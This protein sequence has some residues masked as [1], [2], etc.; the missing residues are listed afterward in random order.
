[1]SIFTFIRIVLNITHRN[2]ISF[3]TKDQ[4]VHESGCVFNMEETGI[5]VFS[6]H[7]CC[8]K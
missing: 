8:N 5:A 2:I 1:M 6:I 4:L 7:V 3:V